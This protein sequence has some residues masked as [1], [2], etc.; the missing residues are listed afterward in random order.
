MQRRARV[1]AHDLRFALDDTGAGFA[2]LATLALLEPEFVKV[3]VSLVRACDATPFKRA[4]IESLLALGQTSRFEV[5]AEGIETFAE[6]TT[7][8]RLGVCLGQGYLLGRPEELPVTR[9]VG[10][11][12]WWSA[13]EARPA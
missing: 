1:R 11:S 2:G 3:D 12:P 4:I 9:L 6:F 13:A 8:R 5:I 7:L 10:R